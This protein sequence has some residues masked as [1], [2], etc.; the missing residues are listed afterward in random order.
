MNTPIA[1]RTF[2][3]LSTGGVAVA[4]VAAHRVLA[5]EADTVVVAPRE[6]AE[7]LVNPGMGFETFHAMNGEGP[8][9]RPPPENYPTCSVA[10]FRLWWKELEPEEGRYRFE[11]VSELLAK[12]RAHHQDLALRFM[13]WFSM[14]ERDSTPEW[15]K[16]KATRSFRCKFHRWAGP[17]RG[18]TEGDYWAPDFN[19]PFFLDRQ[20]GLVRAFGEK[21]NGHPELAYLDIG[22]IGNWGEWHTSNTIPPVPMPTEENA[23]KVIDWHLQAW[24]RTPLVMNFQYPP[25]M[26]YAASRGTG[27]RCDG[28]DSPACAGRVES[29]FHDPAVCDA[30]KRGPVT[31]EPVLEDLKNPGE[32]F[33]RMLRWHASS[34]NAKSRSIPDDALPHLD[35]F[36]KRCGYRFVLRELRVPRRIARGGTLPLR[37]TFE[38]TGVAPPYKDYVLA[39]RL[40]RGGRSFVLDTGAKLTAWLPGTHDVEARLTLPADLAPGENELALGI[41]D[42]HRR[43]PKVKLANAG[44]GADGWYP[45][46]RVAVQ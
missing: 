7:V 32:T 20:E 43:D 46:G 6:I 4:A 9:K 31:G 40:S 39:V 38:N 5:D 29:Q 41:L 12:G 1:R 45:L 33:A 10:Y 28:V 16:R 27:W 42:P 8:G 13:P 21:F 30:W 25:G 24:G 3:G 26:S 37:M 17:K 11:R 2:L 14:L 35:A 23:R 36:L 22:S 34:L 15:F 19:D 18:P 44:R